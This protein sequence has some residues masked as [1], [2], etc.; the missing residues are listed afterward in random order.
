MDPQLALG[1][2]ILQWTIN[3]CGAV[4]IWYGSGIARANCTGSVLLGDLVC[5][6]FRTSLLIERSQSLLRLGPDNFTQTT[7]GSPGIIDAPLVS[8]LAGINIF[9]GWLGRNIT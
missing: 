4:V 8:K 3:S 1:T 9:R 2:G 7:L 6:F 5:T